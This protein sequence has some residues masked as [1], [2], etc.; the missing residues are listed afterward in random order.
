MTCGEIDWVA[1][2]EDILVF[3]EVKTRDIDSTSHPIFAIDWK[4][5]RRLRKAARIY[6]RSLDLP[7]PPTFRFDA[8][9]ILIHSD[10]EWESRW[11][12]RLEI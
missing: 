7:T 3:V 6:I 9:E 11:T 5:R 2:D 8:V 4:K 1:V 10:W 12:P